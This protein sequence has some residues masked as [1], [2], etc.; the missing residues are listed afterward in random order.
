[1]LNTGQASNQKLA[2]NTHVTLDMSDSWGLRYFDFTKR[3]YTYVVTSMSL[4]VS[5]LQ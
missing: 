1:M 2:Q 3:V 4:S 5:D